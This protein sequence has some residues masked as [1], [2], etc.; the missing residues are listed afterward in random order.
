MNKNRAYFFISIFVFFSV[1]S[2]WAMGKPPSPVGIGSKVPEFSLQKED[3]STKPF[4]EVHA[5]EHGKISVLCFLS[6]ECPLS[7]IVVES[8]TKYLDPL[9]EKVAVTGISPMPYETWETLRVY[10]KEEKIPFDLFLDSSGELTHL[11]QVKAV[12]VF[13]VFDADGVLRFRGELSGMK[14]AVAALT[15]GKTV[16]PSETQLVGCAVAKRKVKLAHK[17]PKKKAVEI[18]LPSPAPVDEKSKFPTDTTAKIEAPLQP[19]SQPQPE[20]QQSQQQPQIEA[21]KVEILGTI[22]PVIPA[23][24]PAKATPPPKLKFKA[25]AEIS[26]QLEEK[27]RPEK[28]PSKKTTRAKVSPK[29]SQKKETKTPS[30]VVV[31]S[32]DNK[33]PAVEISQTPQSIRFSRRW[34]K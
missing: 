1:G 23:E 16:T 13:F 19:E 14:T 9:R 7:R 24:I 33:S 31:A 4:Q 2:V 10:Q 26:P 34:G 29:I 25:Q 32:P 22:T 8:A 21:K 6:Y 12:P 3:G 27:P 11:F 15:E 20:A 30:T 28:S 17:H 18:P 5:A